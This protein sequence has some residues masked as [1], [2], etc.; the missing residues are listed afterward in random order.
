MIAL[1]KDLGAPRRLTMLVDGESLFNDATAIVAFNI[2]LGLVM[3][4]AWT[5][6]IVGSAA[7]QFVFVFAGGLLLGAVIGYIMIRV[8]A[9]AK[10]DPL[11]E[12]AFS[13]VVAYAAF[14]LANYY[15]HLSGVMAAVGAGMVVNYYGQTR[16]TQEV[17]AYLHHFWEYASFVANSFIFLLL[18]LTERFL[19]TEAGGIPRVALYVGGAVLSITLARALIVFGIVPLLNKLPRSE[20]ISRRM[21]AVIFW[22]GLRGALPIGLAVSLA[23][24][25]PGRALIVQLTLGVVL[26]TLMV[27]G[28]TIKRLMSWLR[29]DEATPAES[30]AGLNASEAALEMGLRQLDAVEKDWVV[31]PGQRLK[32]IRDDYRKRLDDTRKKFRDLIQNP[33]IEASAKRIILWLQAN[34]LERRNYR[35]RF[36][37]G[38]LS[39][40]LLREFEYVLDVQQAQ[41]LKGGCPPNK[42]EP[43][44]SWI[45]VKKAWFSHIS[46]IG[47]SSRLVRRHLDREL[48]RTFGIEGSHADAS[49]HILKHM[50]RLALLSGATAQMSNECRTYYETMNREALDR[51][52]ELTRKHPQQ[53]DDLQGCAIQRAVLTSELAV[54]QELRENGGLQEKVAVSLGS[55]L[56]TR[57]ADA[58][59][60]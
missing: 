20:P 8:I 28:T 60:H 30:I 27:Q 34:S 42:V 23:S 26:F 40:E 32:D 24:D 46:H 44:Q 58:Q 10:N 43:R 16:F 47:P 22:G 12:I 18:G 52:G 51:L 29:L 41:I 39:E 53:M 38:F 36:E 50:E 33:A 45:A 19:V 48:G 7:V 3:S 1:F 31:V 49:S 13:T 21:Q 17:R 57:L 4:G 55:E 59:H 2:L 6:S 37:Q 15:L 54:I 5:L 25:F 56:Q 11:I 9:M 35:Q 14:I